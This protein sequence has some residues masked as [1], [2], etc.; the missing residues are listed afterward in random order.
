MIPKRSKLRETLAARRVFNPWGFYGPQP[1][2]TYYGYKPRGG[3]VAGWRVIARG[4]KLSDAWYDRGARSFTVLGRADKAVKLA[5][6]QAWAADRFHVEM[7]GKDPFGGYGPAGF[8]EK[9][10]AQILAQPEGTDMEW[11]V[12]RKW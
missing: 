3:C 11:I 6:A 2:I 1:Y 10:I 8:I 9:R 4:K 12:G 7:W 5:E